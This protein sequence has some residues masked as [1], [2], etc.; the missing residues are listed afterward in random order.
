MILQALPSSSRTSAPDQIKK[1]ENYEL[2]SRIEKL[3]ETT[4]QASYVNDEVKHLSQNFNR[5]KNVLFSN[6]KNYS[7]NT[8]KLNMISDTILELD[9]TG[10]IEQIHQIENFKPALFMMIKIYLLRWGEQHAPIGAPSICLYASSLNRKILYFVH[11]SR[12]FLKFCGHT[13]GK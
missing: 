2:V 11:K 13:H 3:D 7:K 4:C 6:I 8:S 5:A 9:Q 10:I 1:P 12:T